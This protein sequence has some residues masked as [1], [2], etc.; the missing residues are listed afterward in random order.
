MCAKVC[1]QPQTTKH[2]G[3][4]SMACTTSHLVEAWNHGD[5]DYLNKNTIPALLW[6]RQ[7]CRGSWCGTP[8]RPPWIRVEPPSQTHTHLQSRLR[9]SLHTTLWIME[10]MWGRS[11]RR[12]IVLM[13]VIGLPSRKQLSESTTVAQESPEGLI[14]ISH[15]RLEWRRLTSIPVG[16]VAIHIRY[17]FNFLFSDYGEPDLRHSD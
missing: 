7:L 17:A 3:E 14:Y 11:M 4:T 5:V 12:F 10:P 13:E 1:N 2:A 16:T 9:L 15:S 8:P 6:T